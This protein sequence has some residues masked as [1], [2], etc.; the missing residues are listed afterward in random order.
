M[1]LR[2]ATAALAAAGA[3]AAGCGDGPGTQPSSDA[4]AVAAVAGELL[5]Q[6][7]T[8]VPLYYAAADPGV[9]ALV[10]LNYCTRAPDTCPTRIAPRA[11]RAVSY[12]DILGYSGASR[13]VVVFSWRIA[14]APDGT[15]N[16][17]SFYPTLTVRLR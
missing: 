17:A 1:R 16:V 6:N 9:L 3:L 4:L 14:P 13:D 7:R 5:L 8:D 11:T 2:L 10:D 12:G 15:G